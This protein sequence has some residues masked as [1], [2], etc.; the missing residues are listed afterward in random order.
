VDYAN[1]V[2]AKCTYKVELVSKGLA[3]FYQEHEAEFRADAGKR[4]LNKAV[5]MAL[6]VYLEEEP[7]RWAAFR[8]LNATERPDNE[9]FSAY[10]ARWEQN[11]PEEH[12]ATVQGVQ[13]LFGL[14]PTT[15]ARRGSIRVNNKAAAGVETSQED[16]ANN[17]PQ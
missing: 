5:A 9:P 10:L 7:G 11:T 8:W 13:R 15:T 12:K 4:D 14:A 17:F 3:Q 1:D 16:S 6:L 2:I